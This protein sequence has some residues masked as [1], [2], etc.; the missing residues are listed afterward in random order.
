MGDG[1]LTGCEAKITRRLAVILC[2]AIAIPVAAGCASNERRPPASPAAVDAQ[3]V[4]VV[5]DRRY[6]EGCRLMK[7]FPYRDAAVGTGT[8][9]DTRDVVKAG[10]NVMYMPGD[11]VNIGRFAAY[12]CGEEQ[13]RRI[14]RIVTSR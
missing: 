11:A 13:L 5:V 1:I 4:R 9:A 3:E 14:P 6:L 2:L 10:G 7:W 12:S 8:G